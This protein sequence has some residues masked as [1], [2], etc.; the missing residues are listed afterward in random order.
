MLGRPKSPWS[1]IKVICYLDISCLAISHPEI[2][3]YAVENIPALAIF[4]RLQ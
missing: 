1:F 2:V 4:T 3:N